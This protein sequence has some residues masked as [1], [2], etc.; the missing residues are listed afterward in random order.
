MLARLYVKLFAALILV[1]ALVASVS[2]AEGGNHYA[3]TSLVPNIVSTT[4]GNALLTAA[5]AN[6]QRALLVAPAYTWVVGGSAHDYTADANYIPAGSTSVT[7]DSS[8]L[9]GD[10]VITPRFHVYGRDFVSALAR[11]ATG[12]RLTVT[13]ANGEALM[14]ADSSTESGANVILALPPGLPEAFRIDAS[15]AT[16]IFGVGIATAGSDFV[17]ARFGLL[18]RETGAG[19]IPLTMVCLDQYSFAGD[20]SGAM[21]EIASLQGVAG[22]AVDT[23]GETSAGVNVRDYRITVSGS[24]ITIATSAAGAGVYTARVDRIDVRRRV[25]LDGLAI[26]FAVGQVKGTPSSGYWGELR[27]LTITPL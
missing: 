6:A 12:L 18:R 1:G 15:V 3:V 26:A 16:N 11:T 7:R 4:A 25:T 21:R 2:I 9:L 14:K 20:G 23:S 27:S 5:D 19:N 13:N 10:G 24:R 17:S 8:D 22:T